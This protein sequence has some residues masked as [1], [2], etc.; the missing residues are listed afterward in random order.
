MEI[1]YFYYIVFGLL[2][3]IVGTDYGRSFIA[4]GY[5]AI[6]K[7]Y[8]DLIA[9]SKDAKV[10]KAEQFKYKLGAWLIVTGLF[11]PIIL[12]FCAIYYYRFKNKGVI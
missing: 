8:F 6:D 2:L 3:L 9:L 4:R 1:E 10:P 11:L 12:F 7:K 5:Y